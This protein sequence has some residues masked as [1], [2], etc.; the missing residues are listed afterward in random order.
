MRTIALQV[1]IVS[2]LFCLGCGGQGTVHNPISQASVDIGGEQMASGAFNRA[3][4]NV[5]LASITISIHLDDPQT[6]VSPPQAFPFEEVSM[7]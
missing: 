6:T 1:I 7:P 2:I 3:T 5:P 4:E